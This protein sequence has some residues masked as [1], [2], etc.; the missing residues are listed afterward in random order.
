LAVVAHPFLVVAAATV[1][2]VVVVRFAITISG[3]K[4]AIIVTICLWTCAP[5]FKHVAFWDFILEI[6]IF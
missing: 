4:I 1:R 3:P 2:R 5:E 6:S